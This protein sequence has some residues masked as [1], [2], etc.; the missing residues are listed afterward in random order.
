MYR[1]LTLFALMFSAA[2]FAQPKSDAETDSIPA[3]NVFIPNA[4]SPNADGFNDFWRPV[5]EGRNIETYDLVIMNRN[6]SE[7][8]RTEDPRE[9]WNGSIR[10][11]GFATSPSVYI[12]YINMRTEGDPENYVYK[13][14]ITVVR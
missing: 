5:I 12:Y 8:F 13:G 7:V 14:H 9:G 4:F 11:G 10:G 1:L 2:V 6:G 3:L